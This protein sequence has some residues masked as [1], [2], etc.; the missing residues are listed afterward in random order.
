MVKV[1]SGARKEIV[2]VEQSVKPLQPSLVYKRKDCKGGESI[3]LQAAVIHRDLQR[4]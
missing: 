4:L 1:A 3:E 2:G